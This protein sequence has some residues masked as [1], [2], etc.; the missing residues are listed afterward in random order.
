MRLLLAVFLLIIV[1][2]I[3][4]YWL[5]GNFCKRATS[6][7]MASY[8]AGEYPL[9]HE[10]LQPYKVDDPKVIALVYYGEFEYAIY[11]NPADKRGYR[12]VV[13]YINNRTMKEVINRP[14]TVQERGGLHLILQLV[15]EAYSN[16][17]PIV[18][19]AIAGNNVH[20]FDEKT[21]AIVIGKPDRPSF[22]H[23]HVW[24]RGNPCKCYIEGIP[25]AGPNPGLIF[26][27]MAKTPGEPGNDKKVPWTRDEMKKVVTFLRG[28]IER[29]GS[30][31][32]LKIVTH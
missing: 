15:E 23:G 19:T 6:E 24:G 18:Q 27:M 31:Y 17:V 13:R 16:I 30:R 7:S 26:D 11:V 8:Y 28:E 9:G 3:A 32:D 22:L 14:Y 21:G 29:L 5:F 12:S 4:C 20:K 2:V 10:A 1:I 25:L